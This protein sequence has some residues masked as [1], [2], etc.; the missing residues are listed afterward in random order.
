M[1]L[2]ETTVLT[3]PFML[4]LLPLPLHL[5]FLSLSL[6]LTCLRSL[7][8]FLY[9]MSSE[10]TKPKI[11]LILSCFLFFFSFRFLLSSSSIDRSH[12]DGSCGGLGRRLTPWLLQRG[13]DL[14][15]YRHSYR[16]QDLENLHISPVSSCMP[17]RTRST[18]GIILSVP[19]VR[20]VFFLF[21]IP[22][23]FW[24]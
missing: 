15:T 21:K 4:W 17:P 6:S 19:R 2:T 1:W 18:C 22:H 13:A 12:G 24:L 16:L 5:P 11:S 20:G 7:F 3:S 23:G 8:P 10:E 9:R 14:C